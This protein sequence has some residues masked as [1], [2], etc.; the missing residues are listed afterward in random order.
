MNNDI[1]EIDK[2]ISKKEERLEYINI[3]VEE[4]LSKAHVH[5]DM[6]IVKTAI[7][8]S[9]SLGSLL[10]C[11]IGAITNVGYEVSLLKDFIIPVG[12]ISYSGV[13]VA[14]V[15]ADIYS[16]IKTGLTMN[17][18]KKYLDDNREE[19][20]DYDKRRKN[21]YSDIIRLRVERSN[22]IK[23]QERIEEQDVIEQQEV[24]EEPVQKSNIINFSERAR[25]LV[26]KPRKR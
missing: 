14:H 7:I 6:R 15:F 20:L 11:C 16:K 2:K 18:L 26:R 3:K 24:I 21:I 4:Y 1:E 25:V 9:L 22:L 5:R 12:V 17:N 13:C 10:V 8:G 19:Y 23:E